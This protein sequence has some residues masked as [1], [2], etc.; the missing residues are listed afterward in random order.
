LPDQSPRLYRRSRFSHLRP[1]HYQVE[2]GV[3]VP[4][5]E[6]HLGRDMVLPRSAA[7][8]DV[9]ATFVH[10]RSGAGAALSAY[11][12]SATERVREHSVRGSS[13]NGDIPDCAGQ[14]PAY[15]S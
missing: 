6:D 8:A 4:G 11:D 7:A 12:G 13:I 3:I 10:L 14:D 9:L 1:C 2:P 15:R 5:L